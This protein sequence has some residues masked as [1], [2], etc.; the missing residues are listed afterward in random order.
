VLQLIACLQRKEILVFRREKI[1]AIERQERLPR[2]NGLAGIVNVQ[3]ADPAFDLDVH[4]GLPRLVVAH[5]AER[6]HGAIHGTACDRH[7]ADAD[8]LLTARID[9]HV[10]ARRCRGSAGRR[11][12]VLGSRR[13]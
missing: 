1:R 3:I 11:G 9:G 2:A 8:Q 4:V 13:L 5:D 12:F 6:A 10:A 7:R